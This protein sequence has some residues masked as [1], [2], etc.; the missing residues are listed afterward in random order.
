MMMS[1]RRGKENPCIY[2]EL[3]FESFI[4]FGYPSDVHTVREG[5]P[6]PVKLQL[7]VKA[8]VIGL[9]DVKDSG[10]GSEFGASVPRVE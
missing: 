1:S 2:H 3:Q 5:Q 7:C 10:V 6:F 9:V 4:I 8:G